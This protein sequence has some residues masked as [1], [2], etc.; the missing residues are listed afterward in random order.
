MKNLNTIRGKLFVY[1]F[2]LFLI[3]SLIIGTASYFQAKS[4]MDQLGETIIKNSVESSLQIIE[5]TNERV[6]SGELSL[7]QAQE[8]V[9]TILIGEMDSEGK[10]ALTNPSNLGENG[11]I[12]ILGHDGTLLGHPTREG[13][14]LW[15]SQDS[16]GNYYIREVKDKADAGGGFTYYEFALPGKTEEAMKLIYSVVDPNWNW[17]I[18][19]GSYLQDFNAPATS[20]LMVI[21]ATVVGSLLLATIATILFSRHLARP[22]HQLAQKVHQVSQ[23]DLTVELEPMNRKDEIGTLNGGFNEMCTQLK[24][25]ITDVEQSIVGIQQTS[26]NLTAVAEETNAYGDDIVKSVNAVAEGASMQAADADTTNRSVVEFAKVIE[27]LHEKN[28]AMLSSSDTMQQSNAEGLRNLLVLKEHSSESITLIEQMQTVCTSLI[29]KVKEIEGIVGTITAISDQTN[30]LA[31]NASIEAARAG[32]HGKG[33]AVVADE[34]RKLADQTTSATD[35][36]Q[37]TLRG[38]EIETNLVTTEMMKTS[39]IVMEQN[40]AVVQTEHSFK[41]IENAVQLIS[42]S[43]EDVSATIVELNISKT[44]IIDSIERISR[45][46]EENAAMS[47]EMT[48][49]IEEQQ[50]AMAV[51]THASTDLTEEI[52]DLQQAIKRFMI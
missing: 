46:S 48:A 6:K 34:V 15:E 52:V 2:M 28:R 31:L 51:V 33:F 30:L 36:V 41:E 23:G 13:D 12:Y 8:A 42:H 21:I 43:I 40:D 1:S 47:E 29:S 44:V 20:L 19:S 27:H 25:L 18:A 7:E 45:V 37:T 9:K 22:L 16:S 17:I 26:M 32:E 14:S 11:Y 35:L 50:N 10:R 4:G 39:E 49:S 3:P 24:A 5:A 38:I